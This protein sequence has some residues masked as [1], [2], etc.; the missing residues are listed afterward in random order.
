MRSTFAEILLRPDVLFTAATLQALSPYV[1]WQF[2][3]G[4]AMPS[5]EL[6]YTPIILWAFG[7]LSFLLGTYL[8]RH[9]LPVETTF[10][11]TPRRPRVHRLT[12]SLI[13]VSILQIAFAIQVYGTLPILSY[14][15]S[16]GRI[17]VV[18]ANELQ[19]QSAVG[20][21]ALLNITTYLLTGLLLELCIIAIENR[22][23]VPPVF[24]C[25]LAMA[26]FNGLI[27]GK[28]NGM[29]RL[30]VFL[31]TGL[32][33][34][35]R[36]ALRNL[37]VVVPLTRRPTVAMLALACVVVG[38]FTMFGPIAA[39]R[40]QGRADGDSNAEM[41][42]YQEG[43]LLNLEAQTKQAGLGPWQANLLFPL[44]QMIPLKLSSGSSAFYMKPPPRVDETSPSGFYESIEWAWGLPGVIFFSCLVGALCMWL[45]TESRTHLGALLCFGQLVYSLLLSHSFNE[46]LIAPYTLAPCV[47]L[48]QIGSWTSA[49]PVGKLALPMNRSSETA[50]YIK[51]E[52]HLGPKWRQR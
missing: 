15:L 42:T 20:Q 31:L 26:L 50:E 13:G 10:R 5:S 22:K 11:I 33:M 1:F 35:S 16:D 51:Q 24:Y 30:V 18:S 43:P 47:L 4:R 14:I 27:N 38:L 2:G 39:I 52:L 9:R 8:I 49:R 17:D 37:T 23:K 7:L 29:F 36:D 40:N 41:I 32:L 6:T 48:W 46:F 21:F 25:A 12:W 28:R 34:Y 19:Q 45:Y 44:A 3:V